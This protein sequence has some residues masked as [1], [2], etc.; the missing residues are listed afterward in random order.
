MGKKAINLGLAMSAG[1]RRFKEKWGGKP[2]L[3]YQSAVI[4]R[5]KFDWRVFS[6]MM[7]HR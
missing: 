4:H 5:K 7:R 2:F 1:N 3:P 6:D